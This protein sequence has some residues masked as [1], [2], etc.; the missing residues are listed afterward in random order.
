MTITL[1]REEAQQVLDALL[2]W[3]EESSGYGWSENDEECVALLRA[4]LAQPEPEPVAMLERDPS[5]GRLRVTYE[6]AVTELDEG[7]YPLYVKPQGWRDNVAQ[8]YLK[9]FDEGC[10]KWRQQMKFPFL[11]AKERLIRIMGTFDLATGHADTF[12][13]LLDSLE[14]ELR[15][16]L[17]HYRE[18]VKAQLKSNGWPSAWVKFDEDDVITHAELSDGYGCDFDVVRAGYLPLYTAPPKKEW[19]G[20]TDEE[21]NELCVPSGFGRGSMRFNL[22]VQAIEAKL[23]EKNA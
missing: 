3:E 15:D 5:I 23:K 9:G 8:A 10:K 14:L 16:V 19:V 6:D 20:L 18:A 1:T 2:A 13:E 17:G 22:I 12:D 11:Q 4:R 21:I 7:V